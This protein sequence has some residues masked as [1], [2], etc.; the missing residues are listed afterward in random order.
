MANILNAIVNFV[1]DPVLILNNTN[2]G[3]NRINNQGDALEEYVKYLFANVNR[4]TDDLNTKIHKIHNTFS[5]T[6]NKNN[7]PDCMLWNQ[8][9]I[10]IK[11]LESYGAV[12]LNSSYPKQKLYSNSP[13]ITETCKNCEQWTE[14]EMLYVIGNVKKNTNELKSLIFVYGSDYCAQKDVYEKVFDSVKNQVNMTPNIEFAETNEL[15][16][17]NNVDP[18]GITVFR[19]RGMWHIEHPEQVFR[20]AY[21]ID[22]KKRFTLMCIIN[23]DKYYSY[24]NRK[25]FESFAIKNQINITDVDIRDPDN[26]ANLKQSKLITFVIGE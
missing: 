15:G 16:R 2:L 1:S 20:S 24:E 4:K 11:K 14:K 8:E 10:E 25:D 3:N 6:G 21:I 5:Y 13:L 22:K 18:L 12:A 7:P 17:V 23:C 19:V 26:P 9:A